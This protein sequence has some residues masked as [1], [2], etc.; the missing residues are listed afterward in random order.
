MQCS[1][2]YGAHNTVVC[3]VDW[4]GLDCLQPAVMQSA[5]KYRLARRSTGERIKISHISRGYCAGCTRG[6]EVGGVPCG[7]LASTVFSTLSGLDR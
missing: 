5:D 6:R 3:L 1:E 4:T 2:R 7:W